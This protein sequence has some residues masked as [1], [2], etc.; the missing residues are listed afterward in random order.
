M[1]LRNNED[2][3]SQIDHASKQNIILINHSSGDPQI[4]NPS[5]LN[6]QINNQASSVLY[7]DQNDKKNSFFNYQENNNEDAT[8]FNNLTDSKI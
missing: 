2:P 8:F 1:S 3:Q 5:F 4:K 6:S 7:Q